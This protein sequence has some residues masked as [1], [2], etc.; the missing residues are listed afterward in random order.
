MKGSIEKSIRLYIDYLQKESHF[1]KRTIGLKQTAL[2]FFISWLKREKLYNKKLSSLGRKELDRYYLYLHAYR[3]KN[4][5]ALSLDCKQTYLVQ[6]QVYFTWLCRRGHILVSP[7]SHLETPRPGKHLARRLL[8]QQEI[9]RILKQ[10]NT[11][12]LKGIRDQAVLELFYATGIRRME[13]FN[14]NVDDVNFNREVIHIRKGKG[15]KDRVVP[16]GERALE[17]L[18]RYLNDVRSLWFKHTNPIRALFLQ[19]CG[20]R[21]SGIAINRMV[22]KNLKSAG[23]SKGG[24]CHVF[25][26]SMATHMLENG[27]DVRYVQEILGHSNIETT[28]RYT[29]VS[30]AKL[31]E[32]YA[33]SHPSAREFS[34]LAPSDKQQ[35]RRAYHKPNSP[36]PKNRSRC[37]VSNFD[38]YIDE[39][40]KE[41]EAK[42]GS[43]LTSKENTRCLI[44]FAK[45]LAK[46][47]CHRPED[48][49][50]H[51]MDKHLRHLH[52]LKKAGTDQFIAVSTKSLLLTII[53]SFFDWLTKKG[54]ILY[55]PT[56]HIHIPHP[57]RRLPISVLTYEEA[58]KIISQPKLSNHNGYR[59]RA[60]LELLY[61]SGMRLKE[62]R[63]LLVSDVNID[64]CAIL[65]RNGKG[66]RDR[67]IPISSKA[68]VVLQDYLK[69]R[70]KP[71]SKD[72]LFLTGHG[73][74][75][76]STALGRLVR[77]YIQRAKVDKDGS[78]LLFRHS[79]ATQMLEGGA[80]I[81]YIQQFLGHVKLETTQIYTHV[82][83]A[84]LKE[85]HK[86]SHPTAKG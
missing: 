1:S 20:R 56:S 11:H 17:V 76:N 27:C 81:R 78:F 13:L 19:P 53:L 26:H 51:L 52:S 64:E 36:K 33:L 66:N 57:P 74:I 21:M 3:K 68:I 71:I 70:P 34:L 60:I 50:V 73:S 80:D 44:N 48:V 69:V 23:I 59:D 83:I 61:A 24:S 6:T 75:M 15:N 84:Q 12:S 7:A 45:W 16:T 86:K 14:L 29:H 5:E 79:V 32:V 62:M 49:S 9:R 25:R 35:V 8:T 2:R 40:H 4:G 63:A 47:D 30:I 58:R 54:Y 72:Y 38:R 28:Q 10:P 55:N 77:L 46:H 31:K 67:R 22:K 41:L 42:G 82:S 39:Y 37:K 65:I 18:K 43:K 85:A